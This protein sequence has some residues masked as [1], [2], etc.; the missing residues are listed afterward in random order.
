MLPLQLLLPLIDKVIDLIVLVHRR[1]HHLLVVLILPETHH[2]VLVSELVFIGSHVPELP[3]RVLLNVIDVLFLELFHD[4]L[5]VVL[6]TVLEGELL[7]QLGL[8]VVPFHLIEGF[9]DLEGFYG[10]VDAL[11]LLLNL[12]L[13]L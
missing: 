11:L 8:V 10:L 6:L 2:L 7:L 12:T 4:P 5:V 13:F 1:A 9:F 3:L